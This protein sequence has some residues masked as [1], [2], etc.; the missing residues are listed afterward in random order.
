MAHYKRKRARTRGAR[1]HGICRSRLAKLKQR[2]EPYNWVKEIPAWHNTIY[3][4][5]PKRRINTA[6]SRKIVGGV[7][8]DSVEWPLGNQKPHVYYW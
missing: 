4:I 2:G 3:N 7:D 8:P 1:T 5:R 6:L